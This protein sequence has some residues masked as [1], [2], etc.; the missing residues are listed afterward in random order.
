MGPETSGAD[1]DCNSTATS[2]GGFAQFLE[3]MVGNR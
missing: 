1:G 3:R 2:T